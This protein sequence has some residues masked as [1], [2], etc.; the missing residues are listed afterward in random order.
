[1]GIYN[2]ESVRREAERSDAERNLTE[3]VDVIYGYD[4]AVGSTAK[5]TQGLIEG[6]KLPEIKAAIHGN[7]ATDGKRFGFEG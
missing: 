6:K 3:E 2:S 7:S 1:M 4:D 5:V